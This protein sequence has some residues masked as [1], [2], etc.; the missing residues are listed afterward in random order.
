L[1]GNQSGTTVLNIWFKNE[2]AP[3]KQEVLSYLVRV[4]PDPE[5]KVRLEAVYSA[6]EKRSIATFP[7]AWCILSF[8][9]DRLLIRGQARDIEEATQILAI[10]GDQA[11][12]GAGNDSR[13]KHRHRSRSRFGWGVSAGG[14]GEFPA[15][16]PIPA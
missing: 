4:F 2:N 14:I 10:I 9:G 5:E 8:V 12:G 13:A 3:D 1:S 15:C 16:G 11:P 7:T 6:L